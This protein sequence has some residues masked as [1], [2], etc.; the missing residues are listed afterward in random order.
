MWFFLFTEI[1]S[2]LVN[3]LCEH[4]KF[5]FYPPRCENCE[6]SNSIPTPDSGY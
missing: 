3:Q 4:M 2:L 5:N 1:F 6:V